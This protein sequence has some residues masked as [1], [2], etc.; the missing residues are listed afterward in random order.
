MLRLL[1]RLF[2][3]NR[4]DVENPQ[5]RRAYGTLCGVL[6]VALNIALFAAKWLAGTM[7]S[8]TVNGGTSMKC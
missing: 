7:F 4:D 6:G 1:S 8:V 5:V 2:I 3:K